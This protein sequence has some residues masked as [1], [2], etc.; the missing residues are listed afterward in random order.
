MKKNIIMVASAVLAALLMVAGIYIMLYFQRNN[1]E[2]NADE[3]TIDE[4]TVPETTEPETEPETEAETEPPYVSP[5]N[6]EELRTK[7]PH[8]HGWLEIPGSYIAYPV[9]QHPTDDTHYDRL[10]ADGKPD[11]NGCIYTEHIYNR[12]DFEDYVTVL[13][14]HYVGYKDNYMY[15]GGLQEMYSAE[16]YENYKDITVYHEEKELH[17]EFY[18]AVVYDDEHI[19]W[20]YDFSDADSYNS[21]LDKVKSREGRDCVFNPD[22]TVTPEDK[23]IILSTCYNG[24]TDNRFIVIGRLVETID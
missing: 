11:V 15:F 14:G 8:I 10:S 2:N 7:Y 16:N 3:T 12:T 19:P 18:A 20:T 21:F 13:Y 6:F 1:T 22:V 4:T 24:L 23:L 5:K 17:Y 9:V